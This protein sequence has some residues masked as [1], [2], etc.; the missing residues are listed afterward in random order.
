MGISLLH[1][2]ALEVLKWWQKPNAALLKMVTVWL[3]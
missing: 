2:R 3:H 1:G